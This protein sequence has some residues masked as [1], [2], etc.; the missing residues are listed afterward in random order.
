[1]PGRVARGLFG[2][3]L[4]G[5]TLFALVVLN[6]D[7]FLPGGAVSPFRVV[8]GTVLLIE[9][10]GLL[11]RRSPLRSV[12]VARLTARSLRHPGRM[13]RAAWKH[14][15]SAGLTL[16]GFVWIGAG[17]LDLLRGAIER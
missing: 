2:L 13:R 6:I 9:G 10:V 3:W 14:G 8:V 1:V 17:M 16:V 4:A 11:V 7:L 12:V 15:V 5:V